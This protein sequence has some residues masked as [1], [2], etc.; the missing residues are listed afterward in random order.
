MTT[1]PRRGKTSTPTS[2]RTR[3]KYFVDTSPAKVRGAEYYP[4]SEFPRL[5]HIVK[6]QYRYVVTI[7]GIDV[8]ERK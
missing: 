3:R 5:E 2:P 1:P 4:I 7:D 8:Y 6:S